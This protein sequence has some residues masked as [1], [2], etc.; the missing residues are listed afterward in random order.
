[1][2]V[3]LIFIFSLFVFIFVFIFGCFPYGPNSYHMGQILTIWG[4]RY[5]SYHT[6]MG[7]HLIGL[8]VTLGMIIYQVLWV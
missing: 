8:L 3:I 2:S 5:Y 6:G 4:L 1:M 7:F